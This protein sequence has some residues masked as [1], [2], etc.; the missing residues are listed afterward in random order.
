MDDAMMSDWD[1]KV[2]SIQPKKQRVHQDDGGIPDQPEPLQRKIPE[3]EPYPIDRLATGTDTRLADAAKKVAEIVQC[4]NGIAAHSM[5]GGAALATQALRDFEIDGRVKPTSLFLLTIGESGER[6]TAADSVALRMHRSHEVGLSKSNEDGLHQYQIDLEVWKKARQEALKLDTSDNRRKALSEIGKEPVPPLSP[7]LL[8]EEPTYEGL[9]K[10]LHE[11]QPSVGLYSDEGGRFIGGVG[12]SPDNALKTAAGLSKLYDDGQA[13]RVRAGDGALILR[14][15]RLSMHMM[16]Q[17]IVAE[18]VYSDRILSEQGLL[19]RCLVSW[20]PSSIGNRSYQ[21]VNINESEEII[22]YNSRIRALFNTPLPLKKD[23]NNTLTPKPLALEPEAKN[24]WI[25]YHNDLDKK[26]KAGGE[27][28]QV[29][30][31]AIKMPDHVLRMA[32]VLTVFEN[33][34]AQFITTETIVNTLHL[35]NYYLSEA[36][37]IVGTASIDQDLVIAQKVLNWLHDKNIRSLYLALIYQKSPIKALRQKD[38]A[39]RIVDILVDHNWLLPLPNGAE[40]N[41][42]QR[43]VAWAVMPKGQKDHGF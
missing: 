39:K 25:K 2:L 36:L 29:R 34:D 1:N 18:K 35:G 33:T 5:L 4:S 10:L 22:Q 30:A 31:L 3:G 32:S 26:A 7:S 14:G 24:L 43:K 6:K 13:T 15:K 23:T 27:L 9:I 41:G 8:I 28:E 40:I 11:G 19:A 37:R 12:M 17:G 21:S 16:M 42:K 20:P 38:A